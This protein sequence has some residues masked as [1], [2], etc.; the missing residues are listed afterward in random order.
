MAAYFIGRQ[1]QKCRPEIV[2]SLR[3]WP[4]ENSPRATSGLLLW[5]VYPMPGL[6]L[7]VKSNAIEDRSSALVMDYASTNSTRIR[8]P[9][10]L[11]RIFN[12]RYACVIGVVWC[13][14]PLGNGSDFSPWFCRRLFNSRG[15]ID[16]F[17]MFAHMAATLNT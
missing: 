1:L 15:K 7:A 5:Q 13:G 11:P 3:C 9:Y 4:V 6:Y 14:Y 12:E 2:C 10:D 16:N 8:H 17:S